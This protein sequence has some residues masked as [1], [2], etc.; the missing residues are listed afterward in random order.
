VT[1][2][3][4]LDAFFPKLEKSYVSP[5]TIPI[6]NGTD[7]F[8]LPCPRPVILIATDPVAA[9]TIY[10]FPRSSPVGDTNAI[11]IAGGAAFLDAIGDWYIRHSGGSTQTFRVIDAGG[12]GNAQAVMAAVSPGMSSLEAKLIPVTWGTPSTQ[13]IGA[14]SVA[15]LAANTA[16][17]ALKIRNASTGGQR[18]TLEFGGAAVIDVG[19]GTYLQGE[20]DEWVPLDSVST[21]SVNVIFSAAGGVIEFTEGT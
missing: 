10:I 3:V 8:K 6:P 20:A 19:G 15:I 4:N 1:P 12:A 2:E 18:F 13:T 16:R 11:P 21:A 14:A 17:R 5:Y 7:Y 9:G